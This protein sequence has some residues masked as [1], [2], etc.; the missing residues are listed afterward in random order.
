MTPEIFIVLGLAA[1]VIWKA[2]LGNFVLTGLVTICLLGITPPELF[3]TVFQWADITVKQLTEL[4]QYIADL[5]NK[6]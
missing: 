1:F 3:D 4:G 2:G 6:K 5:F